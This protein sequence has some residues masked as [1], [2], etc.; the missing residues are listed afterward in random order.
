MSCAL[1]VCFRDILRASHHDLT[2]HPLTTQV[3]APAGQPVALCP[4]C[5]ASSYA[6]EYRG[7]KSEEEREKEHVE[8]QR[9]I[10]LKIRTAQ[11]RAKGPH[12]PGLY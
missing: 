9:V 12:K 10:E 11:V 4:Y 6:V 3:K 1:A 5:K 7:P 2:E 8:E